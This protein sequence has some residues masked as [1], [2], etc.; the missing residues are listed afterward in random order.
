MWKARLCP[1]RGLAGDRKKNL[2]G[3][4]ICLLA[5]EIWYNKVWI[6]KSMA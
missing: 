5:L 1:P 2:D 3:K 4:I 6:K